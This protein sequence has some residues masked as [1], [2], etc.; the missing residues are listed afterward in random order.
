MC[1]H[2]VQFQKK[3]QIKE[4]TDLMIR[5]ALCKK[6]ER[7]VQN[8]TEQ[9][10]YTP[11]VLQN[12]ESQNRRHYSG[13]DQKHYPGA[14]SRGNCCRVIP[15]QVDSRSAAKDICRVIP[16]ECRSVQDISAEQQEQEHS[17]QCASAPDCQ[18]RFGNSGCDKCQQSDHKNT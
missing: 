9:G 13:D 12:D 15:V 5:Y 8:C 6:K 11:S 17:G 10:K 18:S 2:K 7:R 14:V 4:E 1:Q 3:S 16:V